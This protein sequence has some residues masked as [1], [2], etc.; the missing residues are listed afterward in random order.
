MLI[1]ASG[2]F[3]PGVVQATACASVVRRFSS[4]LAAQWRGGFKELFVLSGGCLQSFFE[5]CFLQFAELRE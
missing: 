5:D 3:T 1:F 2:N 4:P